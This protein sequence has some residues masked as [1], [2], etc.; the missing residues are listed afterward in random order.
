MPSFIHVHVSMSFAGRRNALQINELMAEVTCSQWGR[1]CEQVSWSFVCRQVDADGRGG[2]S[3]TRAER[4]AAGWHALRYSEGRGEVF[5][6]RSPWKPYNWISSIS[7]SSARLGQEGVSD[8]STTP[9][10]LP[11]GMSP[12]RSFA[13]SRSSAGRPGQ[14]NHALRSTLGRATRPGR[15]WEESRAEPG[16]A[17]QAFS[18]EV[19]DV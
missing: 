4:G 9:F 8:S 1:L 19:Q 14:F 7:S 15:A 11:Q 13:R 5:I 6:A 16:N 12:A 17:E 2:G 18:S 3:E 10:G